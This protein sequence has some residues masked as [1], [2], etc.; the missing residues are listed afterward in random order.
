MVAEAT[1]V[2]NATKAYSFF[3]QQF[4]YQPAR[5]I[6]LTKDDRHETRPYVGLHK[7][8]PTYELDSAWRDFVGQKVFWK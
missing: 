4:R 5:E 7:F 2:C 3:L 6:G 8:S 1:F